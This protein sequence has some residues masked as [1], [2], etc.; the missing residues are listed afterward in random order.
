MVCFIPA[1]CSSVLPIFANLLIFSCKRKRP[2]TIYSI[3]HPQITE[4]NQKDNTEAWELSDA[5]KSINV[6]TTMNMYVSGFIGSLLTTTTPL[7]IGIM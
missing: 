2:H 7:I 6:I 3:R 4:E 1:V 5:S